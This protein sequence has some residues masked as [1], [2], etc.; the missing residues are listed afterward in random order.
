MLGTNERT[1]LL[2]SLRPPDG[3][4]LDFAIATTF[5]LDLVSLLTAPIGFTYFELEGD[6]DLDTGALDPLVLLQTVRRYSSRIAVFCQAGYIKVPK[7]QQPLFAALEK[8]VVPVPILQDGGIFHPKVWVLRFIAANGPVLYRVIVQS[9]NLTFDKCWDTCVVLDGQLMDRQK[10]IAKNHPL[11]DFVEALP[12]LAG[13][14]SEVISDNIATASKELRKVQFTPPEPF[15]DYSF[16][17][18][19]IDG[20]V[21]GVAHGRGKALVISPFLTSAIANDLSELGSH[22]TLVS[23][24]DQLEGLSEEELSGFDEVFIVDPALEAGLELDPSD[25]VNTL[26]SGLHAKVYVVEDG[27]G[28]NVWSGSANA[29]SAAFNRNVEFMVSL[30][31]RKGQCG[32]SSILGAEDDQVSFR[33]L[34]RPYTPST[35]PI[36]CDEAQK[37]LEK[38]V[39]ETRQSIA[40]KDWLTAIAISSEGFTM[41]LTTPDRASWGDDVECRT[42]PITLTDVS[43]KPLSTAECSVTFGPVTF[44]AITPFWAF[45]LTGRAEGKSQIIRFVVRTKLIGAPEDREERLLN[46]FL[47]DPDQVL[48]FLLLLLTPSEASTPA[49]ADAVEG[50]GAASWS[51]NTVAGEALLE[52]LLRALCKNANSLDSVASTIHDLR[53]TP[54]GA[55]LIPNGFDDLWPAIWAARQRS[56]R[57]AL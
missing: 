56:D 42:W 6:P 47:R 17:P 50:F 40:S 31:G 5:T 4:D 10:A 22:S 25:V 16:H 23:R 49:L 54:E 7:I 24:L 57:K 26:S 15:E 27:H 44:E 52:A 46:Y 51:H 12:R 43:Q 3:Y 32:V 1:L 34:L 8:T 41:V 18:F 19:G 11:A 29:T 9:R 37:R 53:K 38:L 36:E 39:D 55:A 45:E 21:G 35:D 13:E 33:K 48:R 28:A 20:Y 14:V 2:E 30:T